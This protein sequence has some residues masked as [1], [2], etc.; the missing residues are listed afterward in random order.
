MDVNIINAFLVA[1]YEVL[2]KE[3]GISAEKGRIGTHKDFFNI[4]DFTIRLTIKGKNEGIVWYTM[5]ER[6]ALAFAG[7]MM[8]TT[9]TTMDAMAESAIA[10]LG[11]MISGLAAMQLDKASIACTLESPVI[12]K[13]KRACMLGD[14]TAL[15]IPLSTPLGHLDIKVYLKKSPHKTE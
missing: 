3:L 1:A 12:M 2:G 7:K 9:L 8:D 10:E 11:S 13:G 5:T 15:A 4:S 6:T 14:A